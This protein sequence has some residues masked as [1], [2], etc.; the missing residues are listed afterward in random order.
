MLQQAVAPSSASPHTFWLLHACL[1]PAPLT[2]CNAFPPCSELCSF[3]E[4]DGVRG[5]ITINKAVRAFVA[6]EGRNKA[7]KEDLERIAPLVLNH[8]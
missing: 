1:V 8:R 3:L 7:T 4:I 6:F 5:D 2:Y